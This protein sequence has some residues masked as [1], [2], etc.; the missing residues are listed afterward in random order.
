[1]RLLVP[2]KQ[3]FIL[4]KSNSTPTL[5]TICRIGEDIVAPAEINFVTEKL[6]L[7][8]DEDR[9]VGLLRAFNIR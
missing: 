1:V 9:K 2:I 7:T 4:L 3:K 5:K 6:G 8:I